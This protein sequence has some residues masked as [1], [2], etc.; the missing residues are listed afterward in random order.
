ML[1]I[2]DNARDTLKPILEAEQ[3]N[4]KRLILY[5]QGAG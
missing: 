1:V 4:N 2:S 5:L 3:A